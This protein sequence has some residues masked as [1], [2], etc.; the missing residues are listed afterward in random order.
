MSSVPK[1]WMIMSSYSRNHC[2]HSAMAF[3]LSGKPSQTLH[4]QFAAVMPPARM[5]RKTSGPHFAMI[6]PSMMIESSCRLLG[7]SSPRK[8]SLLRLTNYKITLKWTRC[9]VIGC[10]KKRHPFERRKDLLMS[11]ISE[12]ASAR[13]G[14]VR[15]DD[16]GLRQLR[17]SIAEAVMAR[18]RDEIPGLSAHF[19]EHY[20]KTDVT[21]AVVYR[22][23][24][25]TFRWLA[26]AFS[27]WRMWDL[28]V[29][30]V[31]ADRR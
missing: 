10:W 19:G 15:A 28:H 26:F 14:G 16:D 22:S 29:G 8:I 1:T 25:A 24:G 23:S 3:M 12:T 17:Q 30:V 18:M 9:P 21:E 2:F 6:S 7:I 11:S 13:A 4:V 20:E 27:P 5:A 31:P